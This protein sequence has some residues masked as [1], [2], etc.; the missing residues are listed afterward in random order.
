[1][2]DFITSYI[3]IL[4]PIGL[5]SLAFLGNG[6]KGKYVKPLIFFLG[7]LLPLL[8]T[9]LGNIYGYGYLRNHISFVGKG[10]KY[11]TIQDYGMGKSGRNKSTRFYIIDLDK[12]KLHFK[13]RFKY[14]QGISYTHNHLYVKTKYN[15]YILQLETGK[16]LDKITKSQVSTSLPKTASKIQNYTFDALNLTFK[17]LDKKGLEYN[18]RLNEV[19]QVQDNA[20]KANIF[21]RIENI[22]YTQ[23]R[24]APFRLKGDYRKILINENQKEINPKQI[25][26]SGKIIGYYPESKSTIILS[27]ETVDKE[28]FILS[29]VNDKGKV[30]WQ[31]SAEDLD[32]SGKVRYIFDYK[33]SLVG[34]IGN[35]LVSFDINTGKQH[36]LLKL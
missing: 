4:I 3:W 35:H 29:I 23:V 9:I 21:E 7:V 1:M 8:I 22:H 5:L 20:S 25:F 27:Y 6:L 24:N 17:V 14:L 15:V 18:L 26:I 36:W 30:A 34:L 12:G 33:D 16:K 13:K 28:K 11:F 19:S 32:F 10:G 31:T 2:L